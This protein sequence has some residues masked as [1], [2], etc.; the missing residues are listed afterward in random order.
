MNFRTYIF[1]I[2]SL[3]FQ[4]AAPAFCQKSFGNLKWTSGFSNQINT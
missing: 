4:M 3:D 1:K 2:S